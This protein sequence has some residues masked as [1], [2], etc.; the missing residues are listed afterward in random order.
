MHSNTTVK[1]H[2][3]IYKGFIVFPAQGTVRLPAVDKI[4]AGRRIM[5]RRNF[6]RYKIRTYHE[7]SVFIEV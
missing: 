3:V 2:P 4:R 7:R 5:I 1:R 6:S